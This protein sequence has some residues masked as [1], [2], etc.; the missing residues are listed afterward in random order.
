M[1]KSFQLKKG[2]TDYLNVQL[3]MFK[4]AIATLFSALRFAVKMS[5]YVG[6]IYSVYCKE[7]IVYWDVEPKSLF[8]MKYDV[9]VY[10]VKGGSKLSGRSLKAITAHSTAATVRFLWRF[11]S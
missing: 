8:W 5:P 7:Q 4:Y 2:P 1:Y 6:T 10:L 9:G 3:E 11:L